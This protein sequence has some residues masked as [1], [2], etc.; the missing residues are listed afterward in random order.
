VS[1][2]RYIY[3]TTLS[4]GGDEPTGEVDVT[5]SYTVAWGSPEV[6][7]FGPIEGYDPGSG[8]VVEDIRLEKVEG[9]PRPWGMYYGYI[10]NE[11]DEFATDCIEKI[12]DSEA[13]LEAMIAEAS[14]CEA[15]DRDDA[16]E[17]RWED[18]REDRGSF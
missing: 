15:S 14:E 2:R 1:E 7:R 8:D 18:R 10:P 4:W 12:E 6:G 17:R 16:M 13:H 9:K 3:E 11:D 5:V